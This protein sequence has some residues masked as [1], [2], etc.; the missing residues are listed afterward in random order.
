MVPIE[1]RPPLCWRRMQAD[2]FFT[3]QTQPRAWP[4]AAV[5]PRAL[6]TMA[7]A[8]FP[9]LRDAVQALNAA[10][11]RVLVIASTGKHFSA[12]MALDVFATDLLDGPGQRARR[13][14]FQDWLRQLMHCF[15]VLEQARFPGHRRHAGRLHRRRAGPG[16]GLRPP[17]VQCRR[18]LH[19]AGDPHRHGRR[20]GR[21]A[22]PAQDRAAGVAREMAY[23]GDRVGAERALAIGLVNA[24]LPDREACWPTHWRWPAASPPSR[25][26]PWPAASWR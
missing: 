15:D 23:T 13:L 25:R 19:R 16:H 18:L 12:G 6:N 21:A 5:P 11:T 9:A 22:A 14:A 1:A 7:P 20:P 24:V 3:L 2:T 17:R 8:F 10:A 26:W 4:S